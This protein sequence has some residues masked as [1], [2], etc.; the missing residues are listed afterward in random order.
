[1]K[2]EFG[3]TSEPIMVG[4]RVLNYNDQPFIKSKCIASLDLTPQEAYLFYKLANEG[5]DIAIAVV[6][7]A[8]A[9]I[10]KTIS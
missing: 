1:M 5:N 8:K 6:D 10:N 7:V 9:I 2:L 3:S 4:G